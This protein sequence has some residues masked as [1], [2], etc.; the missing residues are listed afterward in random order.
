MWGKTFLPE[1]YVRKNWQNARI[2]PDIFP[3]NKI[4]LFGGGRKSIYISMQMPFLPLPSVAYA[5]VKIINEPNNTS[6][7]LNLNSFSILLS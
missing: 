4:P 3:Q 1:V 5:Y 6:E 2:L 7:T